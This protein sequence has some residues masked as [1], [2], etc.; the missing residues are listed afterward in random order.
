MAEAIKTLP[1]NISLGTVLVLKTTD[2]KREI[3]LTVTEYAEATP[4]GPAGTWSRKIYAQNAKQFFSFEHNGSE[5]SHVCR[6]KHGGYPTQADLEMCEI[7]PAVSS[8]N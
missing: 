8:M 2:R 3:V 5:F 6:S 4:E 1:A 7:V